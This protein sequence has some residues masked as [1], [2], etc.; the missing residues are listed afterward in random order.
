MF[1]AGLWITWDKLFAFM[2]AALSACAAVALTY[3]SS[4]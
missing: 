1:I 4:M 3:I 2:W